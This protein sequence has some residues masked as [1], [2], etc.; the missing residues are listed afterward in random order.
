MTGGITPV[1]ARTHPKPTPIKKSGIPVALFSDYDD[2]CATYECLACGSLCG[3][4]A[5]CASCG[6]RFDEFRERVRNS[7]RRDDLDRWANREPLVVT[8]VV[9]LEYSKERDYWRWYRDD[10]A[11]K[12]EMDDEGRGCGPEWD[13]W[14]AITSWDLTTVGA[15]TAWEKAKA[16]IDNALKNHHDHFCKYD[17]ER[18]IWIDTDPIEVTPKPEPCTHGRIRFRVR[19]RQVSELKDAKHPEYPSLGLRIGYCAAPGGEVWSKFRDTKDKSDSISI[20]EWTW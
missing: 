20:A 1:I 17:A 2:H 3:W 6:T 16:E 12:K 18:G 8:K 10:P 9:V 11:C 15:V 4:G 7:E 13:Q 14:Y 5:F 19:V